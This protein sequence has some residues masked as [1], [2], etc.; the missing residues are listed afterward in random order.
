MYLNRSG[1]KIIK[2]NCKIYLLIDCIV[3]DVGLEDYLLIFRY[4]VVIVVL[5]LFF[6]YLILVIIWLILIFG[7]K[8]LLSSFKVFFLYCYLVI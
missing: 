1:E 4:F 8:L 6:V 7:L 5:F 3:Y 2:F